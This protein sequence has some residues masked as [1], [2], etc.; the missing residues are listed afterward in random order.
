MLIFHQRKKGAGTDS[1]E[2]KTSTLYKMPPLQSSASPQ[3]PQAFKTSLSSP[4]KGTL[5]GCRI[6]HISW[7]SQLSIDQQGLLSVFIEREIAHKLVTIGLLPFH[8]SDLNKILR[9]HRLLEMIYPG[10]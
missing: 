3:E 1:P 6:F 10:K 9:K 5:E 8:L 4:D 2:Q 7:N